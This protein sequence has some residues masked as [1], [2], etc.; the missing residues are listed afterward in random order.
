MLG[1]LSPCV[2]WVEFLKPDRE[3]PLRRKG[4]QSLLAQLG[5]TFLRSALEAK[6]GGIFDP[7]PIVGA[8]LAA[9]INQA[10]STP[11]EWQQGAEGTVSDSV[12]TWG[13]PRLHHYTLRL[14]RAFGQD[15][16]YLPL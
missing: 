9:G 11:P 12:R 7:Y 4:G 8:A 6:S 14:S 15:A 3:C 10:E 13:S 5:G 1:L 16:L 2:R